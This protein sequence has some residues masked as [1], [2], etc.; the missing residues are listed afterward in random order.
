MTGTDKHGCGVPDISYHGENAWKIDETQKEPYLGIYYH[1]E[2][3]TDCFVAYNMQER[4]QEMALPTLGKQKAWHIVFTTADGE[5]G[6]QETLVAMIEDNQ[7]KI[8]VPA[9]TIV[10]LVGR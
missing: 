3:G 6:S 10:L 7:R 4:E 2:D 1:A 5:I 9:R 8:M